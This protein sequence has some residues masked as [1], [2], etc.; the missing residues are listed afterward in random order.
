LCYGHPKAL[1]EP[2]NST[3]N[4][5]AFMLNPPRERLRDVWFDEQKHLYSMT[6]IEKNSD[7]QKEPRY[8]TDFTN[9]WAV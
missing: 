5:R 2:K 3:H 7:Y 1:E 4:F 8:F 6:S 9:F